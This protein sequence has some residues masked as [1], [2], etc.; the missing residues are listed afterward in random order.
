MKCARSSGW[1]LE[2]LP[3][4]TWSKE[5]IAVSVTLINSTIAADTKPVVCCC[6]NMISKGFPLPL[7]YRC[8]D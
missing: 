5:V 7:L 3:V 8:H 6:L 2:L 1:I 4:S